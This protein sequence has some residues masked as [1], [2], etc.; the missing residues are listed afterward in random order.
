MMKKWGYYF[1][2]ALS[3]LQIIALS[4]LPIVSEQ[5]AFL[6]FLKESAVI[7]T[8]VASILLITKKP[9]QILDPTWTTP[10]D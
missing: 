2:T 9:N 1:A 8:F 7:I 3:F 6:P 5:N 10:V 4:Y